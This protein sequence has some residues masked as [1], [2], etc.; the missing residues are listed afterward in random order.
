MARLRRLPLLL[1]L[2]ASLVFSPGCIYM[3]VTTPLDTNLDETELGSKVGKSSA[4]SVLWLFAWGD[5]GTQA[6]AEDGDIQVIRHADQET[7]LVLLFIYA[8]TRTVVYGD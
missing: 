3:N 5:A 7:L 1:V 4:H 8:R 2:L 6:A